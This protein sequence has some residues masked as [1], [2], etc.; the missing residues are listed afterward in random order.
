MLLVHSPL[1]GPY[2]WTLVA[3]HLRRRGVPTAGA[4]LGEPEGNEPYWQ[5]HAR[6]AAASLT[7]LAAAASTPPVLVAHSGAGPLLPAIA[8]ASSRPVGGYLFVDASL[9]APGRTRLELITA[10]E[11]QAGEALHH[12][13]TDGGRFP[14]WTS[15]DL[16]DTTPDPAVRDS[17]IGDLRPRGLDFFTEPLP[18][19]AGWPDAPGAFLRFGAPYAA[20]ARDA[21]ALGWPVDDLPAGH[22]HMLVDPAAVTDRLLALAAAMAT[23]AVEGEHKAR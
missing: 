20:A 22:F 13:L 8:R 7:A 17:I 4:E 9:P 14:E 16:A 21:A 11:P 1:T 2:P 12:H 19:V 18:T 3:T 10:E 23:A 15:D 5:A 6:T